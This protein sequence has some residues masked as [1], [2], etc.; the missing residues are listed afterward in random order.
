[1]RDI[2]ISIGM[3][4]DEIKYVNNELNKYN[5]Q[6]APYNE[7]AIVKDVHLAL[8]DDEGIV[9]GGLIGKI[10]RFC[11]AIEILWISEEY[12]GLG[13]GQSILDEAEKIARLN[14]CT[15]IHLD[16]YSFQAL[17]FYTKNG[18]VVFGV[19]DEY[20]DGIKRYYLKKNI[21]R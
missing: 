14:N 13:Y 21:A 7:K 4:N 2:S 1:M 8:K 15:F 20:S 5:R 9:C 19:I 3:T 12:R 10:Y 6:A 16:T 17:D 11:L 18:Y